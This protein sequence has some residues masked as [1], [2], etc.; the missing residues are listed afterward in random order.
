LRKGS[1][2]SPETFIRVVLSCFLKVLEKGFGEKLLLRSFSRHF[3]VPPIP[4]L[5]GAA[6]EGQTV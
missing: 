4:L 6:H 5:K 2:E 1:W 3:S